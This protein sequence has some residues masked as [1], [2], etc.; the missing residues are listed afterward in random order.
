MGKI[1]LFH[2]HILKIFISK[3]FLKRASIE[4]FFPLRYLLNYLILEKISFCWLINFSKN[5]FKDLLKVATVSIS[6]LSTLSICRILQFL[7][8]HYEKIF[9]WKLLPVELLKSY[10]IWYSWVTSEISI[11][12]SLISSYH[13]YIR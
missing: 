4:L 5:F 13:S 1:L 3:N 11:L 10:F 9:D 2:D 6:F 8:N 12:I 7:E